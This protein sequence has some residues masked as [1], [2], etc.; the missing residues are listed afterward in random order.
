MVRIKMLKSENGSPYGTSVFRYDAGEEYTIPESL[1]NVFVDDLKVAERISE[2]TVDPDGKKVEK[3]EGT[4]PAVIKD[5]PD[6]VNTAVKA[7]YEELQK[8]PKLKDGLFTDR[9]YPR[10][11]AVRERVNF[12]VTANEIRDA[13]NNNL[14][15][16]DKDEE[17]IALWNKIFASKGG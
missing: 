3:K 5:R 17:Q 4:P 15:E 9:G 14:E 2:R 7:V 16:I 10:V 12:E 6:L 13:W 8:D 11:E 1:A